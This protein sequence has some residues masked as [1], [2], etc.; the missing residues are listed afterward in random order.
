MKE[1]QVPEIA[2]FKAEAE[3]IPALFKSEH[4]PYQLIATA[5]W[6]ATYPYQPEVRFAIAHNNHAIF[7]CKK[8]TCVRWLMPMVAT[9]GKIR[10]ANFS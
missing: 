6:H 1:L 10:V 5:N 3:A 2:C 7:A 4:V 8:T 9:F